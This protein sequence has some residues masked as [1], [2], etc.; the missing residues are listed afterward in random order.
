MQETDI[1]PNQADCRIETDSII[2]NR[3]INDGCSLITFEAYAASAAVNLDSSA[4]LRIELSEYFSVNGNA[5]VFTADYNMQDGSFGKER[6]F[7]SAVI[8]A[9][10]KSVCVSGFDYSKHCCT[11]GAS[12][13]M[14]L[15]VRIPVQITA[16]K[17]GEYPVLS[18]ESGIYC[19]D[20]KAFINAAELTA[21]A[22]SLIDLSEN[23]S[24]TPRLDKLHTKLFGKC[25]KHRNLWPTMSSLRKIGK[26]I[27]L[28]D[29]QYEY[30]ID[31]LM[32]KGAASAAAL[33][34]YAAKHI[35]GGSMK[36]KPST[37]ALSCSAFE[38]HNETGDHI[39]GRNFDYLD[40]PCYVLWTHPENAY[41]SIAMVD[42]SFM[43]TT[44]RIHHRSTVLRKLCMLSPYFCLDGMNE[45]GFAISVLQIHENGTKQDTG[46][47]KMFTTA[48]LR[49]C[50]DKCASV[51][52][53]IEMFKCFDIQDT[54]AFGYSLG[55]CFHYM[56][57]DASGDAAVIEYV[58]NE[59]RIV[60]ADNPESQRLFVT[61]YYLSPD[62]GVGSDK[63]DPE[64]MERLDMIKETLAKNGNVL[65]LAQTFDL[66]SD[67]HLNY[68]HDNNLYDITTLWSCL[69]NNSQ[70]TMSLAARMDYTK[71][72][73]FDISKP[74][75]VLAIDSIEVSTPIEGLG[76]R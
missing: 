68:R 53:A 13:G 50:L 57:T 22:D 2:I 30:N 25:N 7:D 32:K 37:C 9:A 44:D 34:K 64:G 43:L 23:K 5:S 10:E 63:Y 28:L 11:D 72:Y 15:I 75:K 8:D 20:G 36:A 69:Y 56:L 19:A 51:E 12:H 33:V 16:D 58:N 45:K 26:N 14:K 66:L 62:G 35:W 38:A 49:C 54:V 29:Y 40:S 42:G 46:K 52:E 6:R 41:A 4:M 39:M 55:C 67:V 76:L 21:H 1:T 70:R 71:I 17:V 65:N 27:Y 3:H 73:T 18:A 47:I 61:N 24:S 74:L 48:I 31:D 60:R 59:I